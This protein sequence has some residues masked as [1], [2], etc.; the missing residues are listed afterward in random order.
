MRYFNTPKLAVSLLAAASLTVTNDS[1]ADSGATAAAVIIGG[2]VLVGGISLLGGS[3]D[4]G[5]GDYGDY[6]YDSYAYGS[7]CQAG[8]YQYGY[9]S[10]PCP[11]KH[12]RSPRVVPEK[13][14]TSAKMHGGGSAAESASGGGH[15]R[16]HSP[17]TSRAMLRSDMQYRQSGWETSYDCGQ[18]EQESWSSGFGFW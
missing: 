15:M 4:S 16:T 10:A 14:K 17:Q 5:Y 1:R 13:T 7:D 12:T 11:G 9:G 3:G 18:Y 2:V 8:A 6:G